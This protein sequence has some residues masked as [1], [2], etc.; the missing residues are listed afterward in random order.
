MILRFENAISIPMMDWDVS[1]LYRTGVRWVIL[2]KTGPFPR[3]IRKSPKTA[4]SVRSVSSKIHTAMSIADC[5]NIMIFQS[6]NLS[7]RRP[8]KKRPRV[9]PAK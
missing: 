2:G 3:P 5:P 1:F 4:G 8:E 6:E 9:M 7:E